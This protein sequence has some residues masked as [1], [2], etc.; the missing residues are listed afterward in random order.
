M[1]AM[2]CG[3]PVVATALSGVPELVQPGVTGYLVPPGDAQ[4]LANA[5]REIYQDMDTARQV[6]R[7]GREKVLREFDLRQNVAQL[8]VLFSQTIAANSNGKGN[9]LAPKE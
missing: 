5:L 9:N 7:R 3:I 2:A 1:E 8:S 4:A 6:A